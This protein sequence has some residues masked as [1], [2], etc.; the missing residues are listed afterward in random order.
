MGQAIEELARFAT[1]TTWESIPE[2]VRK[3]A[4]LVL[5]DTL[6]VIVAGSLQPEVAGIRS[7][8]IATG[9][10]GAKNSVKPSHAAPA[11]GRVRAAAFFVRSQAVRLK[12]PNGNAR[13]QS[14]MR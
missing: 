9:G 7:R 12:G 8:L 6:G 14:E 11:D 13:W 2:P 3:H 10:R 4:Q 5:L 1:A